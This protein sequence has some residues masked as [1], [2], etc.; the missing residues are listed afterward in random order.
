MEAQAFLGKDDTDHVTGGDLSEHIDHEHER[1]AALVGLVAASRAHHAATSAGAGAKLVPGLGEALRAAPVEVTEHM[2]ALLGAA[3]V[4]HDEWFAACDAN[5]AVDFESDEHDVCDSAAAAAA[6]ACSS[7]PG[8]IDC[9][10]ALSALR[11]RHCAERQ[12]AHITRCASL[13]RL[14]A[15][16]PTCTDRCVAAVHGVGLVCGFIVPRSH[17]RRDD[18]S[19]SP[20]CHAAAREA[21]KHCAA[22]SDGDSADGNNACMDALS[23]VPHS[24][25]E[26]AKAHSAAFMGGKHVLLWSEAGAHGLLHESI[27]AL[28]TDGHLDLRGNSFIGSVPACMISDGES[29]GNLFISRNQFSGEIGKVGAHVSKL[30]VND[31]EFTGHLG[32]AL[33]YSGAEMTTLKVS[34]N[35][36]HGG[37]SFIKRMTSL[38]HLDIEENNLGDEERHEGDSVPQMIASLGSM[39]HYAMAGNTFPPGALRTSPSEKTE[40]HVTLVLRVPAHKFCSGC[41]V[42]SRLHTHECA[43]LETCRGERDENIAGRLECVIA[44][45]APEGSVA[46]IERVVPHV[47]Q[48]GDK[49]SIAALTIQLPPKTEQG[50]AVDAEKVARDIER[51]VGGGEGP[52]WNREAAGAASCD[53]KDVYGSPYRGAEVERVVAR[54][55]CAAGHS[56]DE[57]LHFCPT[58][59][60]RVDER[61]RADTIAK[62]EKPSPKPEQLE[63]SFLSDGDTTAAAACA[64]PAA[65][66]FSSEPPFKTYDDSLHYVYNGEPGERLPFSTALESCTI[67]CR[68][69]AT[70]AIVNCNDWLRQGKQTTAGRFACRSAI[71]EMHAT[72]KSSRN[73]KSGDFCAGGKSSY[74]LKLNQDQDDHA[75]EVCGIH[76]IYA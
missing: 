71:T 19:H 46:K 67:S 7:T 3:P 59:W 37:Y 14:H 69:H 30:L 56:G 57:C 68:S 5:T 23:A 66:G 10:Y 73:K 33:E 55:A 31:N 13:D 12:E 22:A 16:F 9:A 70:I 11:S 8:S 54:A 34:G 17:H 44:A 32:D 63:A 24:L 72:C 61:V 41:M 18:E 47:A 28:A 29:N 51:L 62:E 45:H 1:H 65:L 26:K 36:F 38:E 42:A 4:H 74:T 48:D 76:H 25:V 58:T 2:T 43:A 75:C 60:S 27:C 64:S 21:Q 40:V 52:I 20:D 6:V 15:A 39:K 35:K 50:E 49:L 53:Q